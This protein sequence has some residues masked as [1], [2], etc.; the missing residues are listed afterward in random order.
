MNLNDRNNLNFLMTATPQALREWYDLASE[1]DLIYAQE[2][3]EAYQ[4]ELN[5]LEFE[6]LAPSTDTLQ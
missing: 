2:L 4:M 6:L 3:L 1:D 5:A